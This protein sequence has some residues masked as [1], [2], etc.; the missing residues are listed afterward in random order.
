MIRT[1]H[2][3]IEVPAFPVREGVSSLGAGDA[4]NATFL[5]QLSVDPTDVLR[6]G[7]M[8]NAAGRIKIVSGQYATRSRLFSFLDTQVK[9]QKT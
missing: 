4:F 1:P 8:A 9:R 6:A 3:D 5:Y 7:R 2:E